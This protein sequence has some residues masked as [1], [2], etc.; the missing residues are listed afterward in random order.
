MAVTRKAPKAPPAANSSPRNADRDYVQSL[1]RGLAVIRCLGTTPR[2]PLSQVARETGITRAA[3]R[4]FLITLT[5]LGYVGHSGSEFFLLPHTLEL[6]YG[7]LSSQSLPQIVQPHLE[8]LSQD[9]HETCSVTVLGRQHILY[10]ARVT[11]NRLVG[12]TLSVGSTLPAYCTAAGRVL[13]GALP[14]AELAAYL[15]DLKLERFTPK[16]IVTRPALVKEIERAVRQGWYLSDEETD[17]G[18][19]SLAIP[20]HDATHQV[21]AAINVSCYAGRISMDTM[22]KT[23]LPRV[24]AAALAIDKELTASRHVVESRTTNARGLRRRD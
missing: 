3:A 18:V 4:R 17:E 19:R 13:L 16:T 22:L 23:F 1:E 5:R 6:G 7:Y 14:E 21:V 15:R 9:L 12:A 10:V 20:L 8:A 2:A 24:R 11:I